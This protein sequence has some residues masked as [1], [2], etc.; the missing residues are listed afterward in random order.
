MGNKK[1]SSYN[2]TM[3][4]IEIIKNES[5]KNYTTLHIGGNCKNLYF[6]KNEEEVKEVLTFNPI[7]L[8]CGSN[9]LI[10]DKKEYEHA[11]ILTKF[12]HITLDGNVIIADAGAKL[13]DVCLF[14]YEHGLTGLEFAYGIPGSVGGAIMMNAGAYGGEMKDVIMK[15]QSDK[16]FYDKEECDFGYRHSVFSNSNECILKGYFQL[17]KGDKSLIHMKMKELI[18]KRIEKQPLDKYSA[19][20]TFKR[21]KDFYASQLINDCHLKGY[22]VND[23]SVSMK[24]AGFLINEGNA[25]FDDFMN[26]IEKVQEI[27]YDKTNKRLEC[28]VKI[29]R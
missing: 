17:K 8:G 27:V 6:P 2:R 21:G 26:L 7:I 4:K 5:L 20:S 10:D 18:Q 3:K 25:S 22:H 16:Q 29:I 19:G 23:A 1:I 11:M 13:M 12:N 15:V 28:E 24:H 9:V 14:A